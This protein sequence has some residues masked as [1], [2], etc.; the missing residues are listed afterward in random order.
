MGADAR[1]TELNLV[2]PAPQKPAGTYAPVVRTGNQ[3]YVSGHGPQLPDGQYLKGIVGS[4]LTEEEGKAAARQT[5]LCILSTVQHYLGS[6]DKV[7]K[8]VKVLGM[9]NAAP[10]FEKHPAVIN[11]FSDLLVE[12]FGENGRGARSAVGMGTLPNRIAV[13]I[14]AIFEVRD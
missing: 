12:V 2:L 11:G 1:I 9:I 6:L 4:E 7:V 3:I 13:E 5:G 8:L 10:T 14:E